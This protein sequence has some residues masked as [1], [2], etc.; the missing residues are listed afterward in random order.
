MKELTKAEKA[1]LW[2]EVRAEF[3]DDDVM[4]QV[5]YVRLL[6]YHQLKELPPEEQLYFWNRATEPVSTG[7]D[8]S[9]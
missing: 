1:R 2:D 5:H 8:R 3:P 7:A 9:D 6:H 4:Q